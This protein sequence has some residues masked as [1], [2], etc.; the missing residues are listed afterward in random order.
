MAFGQPLLPSQAWRREL[1]WKWSSRNRT[2]DMVLG[3]GGLARELVHPSQLL[4]QRSWSL[5]TVELLPVERWLVCARESEMLRLNMMG[6]VPAY[7]LTWKSVSKAWVTHLHIPIHIKYL[8]FNAY[9]STFGTIQFDAHLITWLCG[10]K[11]TRKNTTSLENAKPLNLLLFLFL[12]QGNCQREGLC[13]LPEQL[14]LY[15]LTNS[16]A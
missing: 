3:E 4:R 15:L 14:C 12:N 7:P 13:L 5:S 2:W 16:P 1:E 11:K 10:F 8:I 6:V 9:L